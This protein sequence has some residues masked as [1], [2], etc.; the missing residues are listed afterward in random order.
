MI[1]REQVEAQAQQEVDELERSRRGLVRLA[2]VAAVAGG[3]IG[4]VGGAFRLVLLTAAEMRADLVSWSERFGDWGFVVPVLA[5]AL[6]AAAARALVRLAPEAA[7]SGVQR[8]EAVMRGEE[9]PATLR[10]V[11][12]KFVGGALALGSGLALGREGP[13]VQMGAVIGSAFARWA[14]LIEQDVRDLSAAV[15]GA[16]L[17]VAFSAPMGG[18]LFTFEE[19]RRAFT[20]RLA[21]ASLLACS[22]AS[23]VALLMLGAEP[24]FLL[25]PP[26]ILGIESVLPVLALGA[27][28]GA[29]GVGYNRFVVRLLDL[30]DAWPRVPAELKA[31]AIGALVGLLLWFEPLLVGGGDELNQSVL[32]GRMPLGSLLVIL[33][34]RWFLGP[35]SYAAGTPGGLFAPLLLVGAA[36]GALFAGTCNAVFGIALD[37]VAFAII[38]M[39]TFFTAVVRAPFTGI[40]LI[41][42]MTATTTQLMPM[43]AAAGTAMLAATLLRGLPVY[44]TLRLRM[45][46]REA[47]ETRA[48]APGTGA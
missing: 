41:V 32:D 24:D 6:C 27:L 33:A 3:A 12:V 25:E 9:P 28:L 10:V 19:V 22:A 29:L 15:A 8:V 13:T 31:A 26:P 2:V 1:E 34:V 36:A 39:S 17:G 40:V 23:G 5:V 11:P 21:V 44:D 14:R 42:E 18:A 30:A 4:L 45:L 35:L 37:P 47:A 16:G 38:G 20:L 48:T 7:G 46:R 43:L